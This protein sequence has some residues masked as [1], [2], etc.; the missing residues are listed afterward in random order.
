M[1]VQ[2]FIVKMNFLTVRV[3]TSSGLRVLYAELKETPC[4]EVDIG[5]HC[6]HEFPDCA[7]ELWFSIF[8]R[9]TEGETLP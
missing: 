7:Y 4:I 9:G 5:R 8:T 2:Q 6:K 3:H 1:T